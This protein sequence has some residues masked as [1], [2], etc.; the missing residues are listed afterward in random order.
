M[1]NLA[2]LLRECNEKLRDVSIDEKDVQ[3][4]VRAKVLLERES[5]KER[6]TVSDHLH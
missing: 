4:L 6:L 1:D 5:E 3:Q 2:R